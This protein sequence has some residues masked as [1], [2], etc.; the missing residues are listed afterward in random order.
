M[1]FEISQAKQKGR[2]REQTMI[3]D[4]E[5]SDNVILNISNSKD[6][7]LFPK[8]LLHLQLPFEK[9][10]FTPWFYCHFINIYYYSPGFMDYVD[11]GSFWEIIDIQNLDFDRF[12]NVNTA[13][14]F[15][16]A[17]S[18]GT[19]VYSWVDNFWISTSPYFKHIHDIHPILIYGFDATTKEYYCSR[20]SLQ[21]GLDKT[22]IPMDEVHF[23]VESAKTFYF[24]PTEIPFKFLKV[25]DIRKGYKNSAGRFINELK[26]YLLGKGNRDYSFYVNRQPTDLDKEFFGIQITRC[27]IDG[28]KKMS[29]Y[30]LFDYRLL[31]MIVENKSHISDSMVYHSTVGFRSKELDSVV[32]KY[33]QLVKKYQQIRRLYIKQSYIESGHVDFYSPPQNEIVVERIVT[34]IE[35]LLEDEIRLLKDFISIMEKKRIDDRQFVNA[36]SFVESAFTMNFDMLSDKPCIEYRFESPVNIG[37]IEVYS[38]SESFEGVLFIEDC[39]F[40]IH[41]RDA[42]YNFLT[43]NAEKN[44]E[45]VRSVKY[46]P[47]SLTISNGVP[48]SS[49]LFYKQ[50][51]IREATLEASSVFSESQN[52]SFSPRNVLTPPSSGTDWAPEQTDEERW[53]LFKFDKPVSIN[54]I[55]I[56]QHLVEQRVLDYLI[57]ATDI[58]G[59]QQDVVKNPGEMG[60]APSFHEVVLSDIRELKLTFT[61]TKMDDNGY[62]VPRITHIGVYCR[63]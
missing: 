61:K 35:A 25:R 9:N 16:K 57:Q 42:E 24:C 15:C 53:L 28:L 32:Q 29:Q 5:H 56:C 30:D 60:A 36:S 21:K 62:D 59:N 1:K 26:Q 27:F 52:I 49:L 54:T 6:I 22:M 39:P 23:A 7:T 10:I 31:H 14:C 41:D 11:E 3:Y 58:Y 19:F 45:N 33:R 12:V 63:E 13:T 17:I 18:Q 44:N 37:L 50:N 43:L 2:K 38:P 46:Y 55:I 40:V 4:I 8:D 47:E 48:N 34:T 20:F 51:L